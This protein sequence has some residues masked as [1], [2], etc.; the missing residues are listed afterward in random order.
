MGKRRYERKKESLELR[1]DEHHRKIELERKKHTPDEGL[2]HHWE[3]EIKAFE[4]GV[5]KA[6]RQLRGQQ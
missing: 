2:I 4:G 3:K 5:R 1:I 6:Q